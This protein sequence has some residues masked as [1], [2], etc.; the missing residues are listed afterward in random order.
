MLFDSKSQV[1]ELKNKMN[2]SA[3]RTYDKLKLMMESSTP[4]EILFQMKLI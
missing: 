1:Y 3:E 2:E 4:L